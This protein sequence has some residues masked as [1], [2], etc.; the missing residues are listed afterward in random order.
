[1]IKKINGIKIDIRGKKNSKNKSIYV[2]IGNWTVYLDNSTGEKIINS[3]S[4]KKWVT[5]GIKKQVNV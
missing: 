5:I 3:W 1:M 2:T 4:E